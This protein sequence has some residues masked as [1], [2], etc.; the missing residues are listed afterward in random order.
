MVI[1]TGRK[2]MDI[3]ASFLGYVR[4]FQIKSNIQASLM[5]SVVYSA[6]KHWLCW[7]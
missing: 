2:A 5:M 6:Y 1:E 3:E 4:S 7:E